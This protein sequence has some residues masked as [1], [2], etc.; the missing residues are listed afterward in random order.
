[1]GLGCPWSRLAALVF[2]SASLLE[3]ASKLVWVLRWEEAYALGAA[4][5]W[6]PEYELRLAWA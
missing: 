4:Y 5:A 6:G 1:M 3:W 2:L